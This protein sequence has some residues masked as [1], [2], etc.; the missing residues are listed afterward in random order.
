[1]EACPRLQEFIEK[2]MAMSKIIFKKKKSFLKLMHVHYYREDIRAKLPARIYTKVAASPFP[3]WCRVRTTYV[4]PFYHFFFLFT[5]NCCCH[6]LIK[7][8]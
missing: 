7:A 2:K 5:K 8:S 6:K 3:A 4:N 1:M